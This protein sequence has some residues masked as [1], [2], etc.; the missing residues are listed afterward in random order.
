MNLA[1]NFQNLLAR[2]QRSPLWQRWPAVAVSLAVLSSVLLPLNLLAAQRLHHDEA[3]YATWALKITSGQDPWLAGTPIDKPPLF[4]YTVAG[5]MRLLGHTETAARLPSLAATA[6][7]VLLTF[8]LGRRLY[9][10]GTG[11]LAA[12]LVALSPFMLLFAPTAFTDPLLVALVLAG[13]LAAAHRRAGW[14]GLCLGLA[15][16]TKQQG[17]FF[18]P[19][20]MLLLVSGFGL[21]VSGFGLQVAGFRT[22]KNSKNHASRLTPHALRFTAAFF[23]T[24]LPALIWDFSRNQPSGFFE[25]SLTNY[26]GLTTDVAGFGQR[27][28]GFIELL[29]YGTGSQLLNTIFLAGCPLLLIYGGL[30]QAAAKGVNN[31]HVD[32][33]PARTDWILALFS[34]SFLLLHALFSFQVWDRYLLGLIPLLALLL[35]RVLLLPWALLKNW[36]GDLRPGLMAATGPLVALLLA[37]LLAVTLPAPVRDAVNARYPLGSNSRALLGIEQ[38]TAYLQGHVG[39][40]TTLYHHWLGTHWRFY[41]WDY[42]YDLQYWDSPSELAAKAQP[43]HFIAYPA[44]RSDTGVRIALFRAGLGLKEISRAYAPTGAPAIT[45]YK[46]ESNE[47]YAPDN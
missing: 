30:R 33:L 36:W 47:N 28:Q 16:A 8:W 37:A 40:N 20:V 26:G 32:P 24:M 27:W 45:L 43:G 2:L 6:L 13:C 42:P 4:L 10:D 15:V 31:H 46:I 19:L 21:Q 39:A 38:I 29:Y 11:A 41:L 9:S 3:L 12:W 25:Q 22:V 7:I 5:A 18:A 1:F 44:W 35:A 17:I 14:A 23:L 34:L